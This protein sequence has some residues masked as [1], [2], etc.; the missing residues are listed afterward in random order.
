MFT[1]ICNDII[2]IIFNIIIIYSKRLL[3]IADIRQFLTKFDL[4]KLLS[5]D[6]YFT[7]KCNAYIKQKFRYLQIFVIV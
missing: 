3:V 5:V 4:V 2:I 6:T 7:G 1:T